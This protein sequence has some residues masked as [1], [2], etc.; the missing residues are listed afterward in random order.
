MTVIAR[1]AAYPDRDFTGKVTAV[2]PSVDP[3]LARLHPGGAGS[4]IPK[5]ELRPGMF[6]TA[7]VLLPGGENARLRA[8]QPR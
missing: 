1:V 5:R 8:A 4:T 2:N 6:A 7:R 3:E